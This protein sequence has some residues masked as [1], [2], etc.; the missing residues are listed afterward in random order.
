[1]ARALIRQGPPVE[2]GRA[3]WTLQQLAEALVERVESL[4][5]LSPEGVRRLLQRCGIEWRRAKEW[6]TSPDPRYAVRKAHRDRLL[7]WARAAPDGAAVWLDQSWFVR[8]PYRYWSWAAADDL[9]RVAQRWSEPVD[10]VALY[11][12]LDDRTQEPF[13]RWAAGQPNSEVTISFLEALMAHWQAHGKRFIVLF[14]DRAPWHTSQRTQAWIRAY[15]RRAKAEGLTRLIVCALPI[16]SPWLMPLESI[17]GHIK[18]QVLGNRQF[19]HVTAL[20]QAVVSAF[21]YR[22]PPARQRRDR[23]WSR[24]LA[25]A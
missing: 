7:A 11:A 20:Q 24:T 6:L 17:F 10:R 12:T 2:A 23:T 4:S 8:W 1:M 18:H 3:S 5:T 25:T 19:E 15:N 22:I 13:L 9:P 14:W 16:R 21:Y